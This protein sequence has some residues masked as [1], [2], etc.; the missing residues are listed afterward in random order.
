MLSENGGGLLSGDAAATLPGREARG[1]WAR[2]GGRNKNKYGAVRNAMTVE[3][4][5]RQPGRATRLRAGGRPARRFA[6]CNLF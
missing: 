6:R 1:G 3:T 5:G 4:D 2:F